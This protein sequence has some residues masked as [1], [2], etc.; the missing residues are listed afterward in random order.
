MANRPL[1]IEKRLLQFN[2]LPFAFAE[3]SDPQY[4]LTFK[5][6][7]QPYTNN[8]HGSYF[9]TI[10][11]SGVL[12][13]G[14]FRA[15]FS[16]DFSKLACE[17]KI[18]YARFIKRELARSGKLWAVQ[19]GVEIIWTNA[20]ILD[21][22][23][24]VSDP[25]R[26]DL[27]NFSAT[28]ELLDG[29]WRIANTKLTFLCNYC[30]NRFEDFDDKYCNDTYNYYGICDETGTTSCLAC[31]LNDY[32]PPRYQGCDWKPLCYYPLNNER[33]TKD[34]QGNSIVVPSIYDLFGVSCSNQMYIR[35]DCD[36]AKDYFCYDGT[37]GRKWK[38]NT[39]K[40]SNSTTVNFCS[41]TDLPTS[42]VRV[43]LV[44]EFVDPV[45]KV[46]DDWVKLPSVDGVP[47][48][49]IITIGYG[50]KVWWSPDMKDPW[51]NAVDLTFRC[52]RTNTP[53]FQLTAGANTITVSGATY[54]SGSYF[55]LD[56][57][58][59]TW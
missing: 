49:G 3:I 36:F 58:A 2:G 53:M 48:R 42:G 56:E 11:E 47:Y 18:R 35:Y 6:N 33:I 50:N 29:V 38:L 26:T 8:A 24:A 20:R 31:E 23:E 52:Q 15:N 14:S 17:D 19:N 51:K 55:Y 46:N 41:R 1:R 7:S 10:G 37:W 45:V 25:N 39:L 44:G 12:Q 4:T 54:N 21:I 57:K 22:S 13:A 27:F 34:S 16:V 40:S 28:V 30:P 5:G 43:R 59:L 9:P 32:T